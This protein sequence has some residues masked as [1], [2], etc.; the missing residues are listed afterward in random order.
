MLLAA[1]AG[2]TLGTAIL[3]K[4][5]LSRASATEGQQA[6]QR[7]AASGKRLEKLKPLIDYRWVLL[8]SLLPDMIDKLVGM[9]ILGD[10]ISN[11]R[12]FCHT[13][14]FPVALTLIG[15]FLY[16]WRGKAWFLSLSFG[17]A[18]HLI[19]DQ[20]WLEPKTLFWPAYGWTFE[21]YDLSNWLADMIH[22][23]LTDPLVFVP[24]IVGGILLCGFAA[25]L[26]RRGRV[27]AFLKGAW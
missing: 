20:M 14:L 19:L 6:G 10:I 12:I 26:L 23:L 9:V 1:H 11:G 7:F 17:C 15:L 16:R 3:F 2:I 22:M 13:L 24:E 27:Y 21:K 8:G 25:V 18:M 5:A 4:N